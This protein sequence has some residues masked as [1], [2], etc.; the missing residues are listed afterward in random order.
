[1]KQR[2]ADVLAYFNRP[3]TSNGPTEAI[4]GRLEHLRGSALGFRNLT[5]Y[6]ARCLL[7]TGGFRPRLHP[8]ALFL[9]PQGIY[10][11]QEGHLCAK[12]FILTAQSLYLRLR[13][14]CCPGIRLRA[15]FRLGPQPVLA[16]GSVLSRP[17]LEQQWRGQPKV[18][19]QG[20]FGLTCTVSLD[21]IKFE[22]KREH[23]SCWLRHQRRTSA[24]PPSTIQTFDGTST[25]SESGRY[26]PSTP[27]RFKQRYRG[28]A[29]LLGQRTSSMHKAAP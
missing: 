2:A 15:A 23:R 22:L 28:L 4:N 27:T 18:F 10:F 3:G 9:V 8:L 26:R 16:F 14:P 6:T 7:E 29:L 25:Y 19:R 21:S 11:S 17:L 13:F 1:L 20:D 5:N 24:R 12:A